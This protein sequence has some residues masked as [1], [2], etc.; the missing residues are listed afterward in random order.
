M[1][2]IIKFGAQ[3]CQP[4]KRLI[5]VYESI[6]AATKDVDFS[7][8]DIDDDPDSAAKYKIMSIPTLVFEK[9]DIEVK[10]LVGL[11]KEADIKRAID[12]MR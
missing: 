9:D 1:I 11:V 3:W 7:E 6:K 5:P 2:S 8:I 10:R 4:C 12:E